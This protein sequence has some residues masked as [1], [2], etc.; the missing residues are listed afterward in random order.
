MIL[1]QENHCALNVLCQHVPNA[2]RKLKGP[3]ELPII[4]MLV[5]F[6]NKQ[7]I[8]HLQHRSYHQECFA[9]TTCG[10]TLEDGEHCEDKGKLYHLN[11]LT[12]TE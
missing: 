7:H 1:H 12:N 11:C 8:N 9:C 2:T 4:C 10:Q 3:T 5:K 6:H